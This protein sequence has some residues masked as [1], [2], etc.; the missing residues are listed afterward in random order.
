[1]RFDLYLTSD[2]QRTTTAD[3]RVP[4]SLAWR[5]WILLRLLP[6]AP[7]LFLNLR[8]QSESSAGSLVAHLP[9]GLK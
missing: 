3:V 6:Q 8:E 5:S 1:M 9:I 2:Y 7:L 4:R